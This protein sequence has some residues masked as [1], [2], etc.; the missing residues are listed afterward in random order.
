[1]CISTKANPKKKGEK[2]KKRAQRNTERRNEIKIKP[3][4][5]TE[6]EEEAV[7]NFALD[8][9]RMASITANC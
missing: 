2:R 4:K 9:D 3:I 1:M 5:M 8:C 7:E 6:S